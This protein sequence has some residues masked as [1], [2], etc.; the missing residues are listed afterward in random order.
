MRS[1]LALLVVLLLIAQSPAPAPDKPM[2]QPFRDVVVQYRLMD[3]DD[4]HDTPSERTITVNWAK[5]GA[6]MRVQIEGEHTYGVFNRSTGRMMFV[7]LDERAYIEQPL[8][9]KRQTGFGVP[10]GVSLVRGDTSLVSGNACTLWHSKPGYG[11]ISLCITSDGVVL[12]AK[13]SNLDDR[14]NL[15][16]TS[17]I[18]SPQPASVFDP[19]PG[20]RRLAIT[21]SAARAPPAGKPTPTSKP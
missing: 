16:A 2:M 19:P 5:N 20:F 6:L 7:L 10:P 3:T 17:V 12:S 21:P 18:Y 1:L 13:A 15:V 4:P 11:E 14:G 9:P 8:D